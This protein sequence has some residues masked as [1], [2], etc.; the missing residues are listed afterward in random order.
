MD[1]RT[2]VEV[3]WQPHTPAAGF[4]RQRAEALD[5]DDDAGSDVGFI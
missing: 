5:A 2:G 4:A 3:G 1:Y